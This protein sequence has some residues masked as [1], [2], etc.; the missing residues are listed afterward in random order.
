MSDGI[1][2]YPD[3]EG[4]NLMTRFGTSHLL[5]VD[6]GQRCARPGLKNREPI[7]D[8]SRIQHAKVQPRDPYKN[9]QNPQISYLP[10]RRTRRN[11]ATKFGAAHH[12]KYAQ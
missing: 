12:H 6:P 10:T 3:P 2:G 5:L 7:H 4:L 1:H 11:T 8:R 9:R